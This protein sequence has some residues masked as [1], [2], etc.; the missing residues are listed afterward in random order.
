MMKRY[1]TLDTGAKGAMILWEDAIPVEGLVFKKLGKGVDVRAICDQILEWCPEIIYIEHFPPR[2]MQG[3]ISTS[4]QWRTFGQIE[5]VCKL[6]C[7]H[8]EYIW[9]ASWTSFTK[10]LSVDPQLPMKTI[11]Q[12]LTAKYF[13]EFAAPYKKRKLYQDG[14]SDCLGIGIYINRD[15]YIDDLTH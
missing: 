9:V 13:P 10:R 8:V 15:D 12:E 5:S 4:S 11:A 2:P 3:V 14:I 7:D 1:L 6:Y